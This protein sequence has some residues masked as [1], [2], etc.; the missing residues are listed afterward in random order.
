MFTHDDELQVYVWMAPSFEDVGKNPES[1][2]F[3]RFDA[4]TA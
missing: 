1:R 4:R 2:H 3:V